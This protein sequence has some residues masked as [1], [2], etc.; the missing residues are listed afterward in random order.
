VKKGR[1][2][3]RKGK[4]GSGELGEKGRLS[5]VSACGWSRPHAGPRGWDLLGHPHPCSGRP[6]QLQPVM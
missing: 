6:Y 5:Q 2:E 3:R 1:G 4:L